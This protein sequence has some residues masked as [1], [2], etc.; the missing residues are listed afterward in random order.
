MKRVIILSLLLCCMGMY[1]QAKAVPSKLTEATVF[2]QGAELTHTASGAMAKGENELSIEGLSPVIDVSS[3]K[4]SASG[5]V[6]VSSYEFSVDYLAGREASPAV[7]KMEDS[8]AVYRADLDKVEIDLKA[9]TG[10]IGY[11][12]DGVA[13]NI[14]GSEKGLAVDE[15]AKTMDYYKAKSV[16]LETRQ[17]ELNKKKE[18]IN[19]NITRIQSQLNQEKVK[20]NKSSG[21]LKL[22]LASPTAQTSNFTLS[23]FTGA[24]GWTPYYEINAAG[25]DKPIVIASKSKVFQ[26]TGMDWEKVKLTLSTAVPSNGKVAPLF[27][28]WFLTQQQPRLMVRGAATPAMQNS[29]S[30]A[31][32]LDEVVVVG[33]GTQ[34]KTE[35]TGSL[36]KADAGPMYV[37]DGVP[38]TEEQFKEIDPS[39]IKSINVLK[40]AASTSI[41][42]SKAANGVIAVTLKTGMEDYVAESDNAIS[43]IYNI[44]LAY[45]IPGNGKA[46]NIDLGTKQTQAEYKYYCAPKLDPA[47]YLLAEISDWEQLGLLSGKANITFEGTYVGETYIDAASTQA[48]LSLTLGTDKRVAVKREKMKDYSSTKTLGTDVQ[49]IFTYKLTV[50]NNRTAPVKMVLKDQYPISSQKSIEVLLRKETTPWTANKEETGVITWEEEIAAGQ[51]REYQLSYSV[52]YP[53]GWN[54]NL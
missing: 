22:T 41:Y 17:G 30:Y 38:Y 45:T 14:S 33:Y 44:D 11:L 31:P 52:K 2:F 1:A 3:L 9:N 15:L 27:S 47:V 48:K 40:D 50:K 24:A 13:K 37:V 29:Y 26:T 5:G 34:R 28:A 46:Q 43:V 51:T 10:M 19:V 35:L 4:I 21:T 8:L 20:G 18:K 6:V 25:A 49:Q 23:Y 12:R 53:K 36:A 16:E 54:L 7:K 32:Q 39:A 42:G